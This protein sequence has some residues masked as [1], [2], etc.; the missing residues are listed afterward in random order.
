MLTSC[1]ADNE[2][3]LRT[4][5]SARTPRSPIHRQLSAAAA[6]Q[7]TLCS[8]ALPAGGTMQLLMDDLR[9]SAAGQ[10]TLIVALGARCFLPFSHYYLS[11][12]LCLSPTCM[13]PFL[14]PASAGFLFCLLLP[15]YYS[16]PT[17]SNS[18]LPA[19]AALSAAGAISSSL[20]FFR[21]I[22]YISA[23]PDFTLSSWY[24]LLHAKLPIMP[25]FFTLPLHCL[26]SLPAT[27][28]C[29]TS[30]VLGTSCFRAL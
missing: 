17:A 27:W 29:W 16:L 4:P 13:L 15:A 20:Y 11:G 26:H 18:H 21:A 8:T 5:S 30:G 7:L 3:F 24:I 10:R 22:P 2:D 19:F 28:A 1:C 12:S 9:C 23:S 25:L 14:S 6:I